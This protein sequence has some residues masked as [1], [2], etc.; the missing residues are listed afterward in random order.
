LRLVLNDRS[1]QYE[2]IEPVEGPSIH[3]PRQMPPVEF[4][5]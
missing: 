1:P 2:L 5:F 4:S 3:A